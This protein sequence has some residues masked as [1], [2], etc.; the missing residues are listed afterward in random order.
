MSFGTLVSATL[1]LDFYLV[2][3]WLTLHH[4]QG[5][6]LT[7]LMLM[8]AFLQFWSKSQVLVYT[9][10]WYHTYCLIFYMIFWKKYL[11]LY[12]VN[13]FIDWFSLL[14]EIL[15]N[16]IS[17][18]LLARLWHQK[19]LF[20]YSMADFGAYGTYSL[21]WYCVFTMLIRVQVYTPFW[22]YTNR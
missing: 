7:H 8:T 10:I 6:T 20:G 21:T 22:Y 2:A 11:S 3:P 18:C 12:S 5:D 15:G 13:R 16:I 4:Y 9:L 19:L 17:S 14:C 1:F